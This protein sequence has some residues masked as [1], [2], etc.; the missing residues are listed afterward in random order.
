M[1]NK[2]KAF[3]P[4]LNRVLIKKLVPPQTTKSGIILTSK[5]SEKEARFGEVLAVGPGEVATNGN[6]LPTLLKKGDVVL[7]PEYHGTKVEMEDTEAEVMIYREN[8]ILGIVEGY[9][10]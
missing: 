6:R 10:H 4:L 9:K 3:Q 1:N 2:I 5:T 7:L 8:D